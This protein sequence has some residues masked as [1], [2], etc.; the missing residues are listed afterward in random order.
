M[1]VLTGH[2]ADGQLYRTSFAELLLDPRLETTE[3]TLGARVTR[4]WFV[5]EEWNKN[6]FVLGALDNGGIACWDA[7]YVRPYVGDPIYLIRHSSSLKLVSRWTI[8]ITELE[9]VISLSLADDRLGRLKGCVMAVAADGT[10]AV[11]VLDG[12]SL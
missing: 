4:L 1:F 2:V 6:L 9:S 11:I 8:F 10:I 12:M 5:T 7:R 3:N